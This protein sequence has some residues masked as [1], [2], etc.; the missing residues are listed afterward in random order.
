MDGNR[1][2]SYAQMSGG[3]MSKPATMVNYEE[4]AGSKGIPQS[5]SMTSYQAANRE[6]GSFV[7]NTSD[8]NQGKIQSYSKFTRGSVYGAGS[9]D[10]ATPINP[11]GS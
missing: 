6:S 10:S 9:N 5:K 3:S 7:F 1:S 2:N 8:L 11:G 4:N